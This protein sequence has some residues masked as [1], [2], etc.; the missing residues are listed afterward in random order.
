MTELP[1]ASIMRW[2]SS[3]W[4]R[5]TFLHASTNTLSKSSCSCSSETLF[6]VPP[7]TSRSLSL[8]SL[9]ANGPSGQFVELFAH[10]TGPRLG[11]R[12]YSHSMVPGGLEVTS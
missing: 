1:L 6:T 11:H 4:S 7:S 10:L 12:G 2:K 3:R 9:L 5:G 8:A